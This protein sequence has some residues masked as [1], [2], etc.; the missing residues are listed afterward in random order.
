MPDFTPSCPIPTHG[1]HDRIQLAH[2][3]GGLLMRRW[4]AERLAPALGERGPRDWDDAARLPSFT[5]MPLLTT[6][7]Y[8]VSPLFFPG[9]D[10]GRLAVLGTANDLA[11]AGARPR[12]LTLALI[13]EEG[14]DF[15]T[16]DRVLASVRE[17]ADEADVR[18]VAGDTKVA[19]RGAVDRL[20]ITT[21]GV[22]EL[23]AP[24]PSGVGSLQP[25]DE[26]LVT[27][28]IGRHGVA[29]LAARHALQLDPAPSSDCAALYP[30]FAAL[31]SAGIRWKSARDATRGG[32]TA[33]LHE[34]AEASGR[35]LEIDDSLVPLAA[36]T[37]GVCELLGLDP[38][39]LACEGTS[40]VAVSAHDAPAAL[41]ALRGVNVAREATRL[42]QVVERGAAPVLI[43]RALGRLVPLDEPLGAP[44]PRIC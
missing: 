29:V 37:R 23:L 18:I 14:L 15:E 41:A 1:S 3:E 24:P 7:S 9:G 44:T 42:G 28:P 4:I 16:L 43:R 32:V 31:R 27:G 26:L 30:A 35:T 5:G 40:V 34:W 17:A 22:G 33:V 12:W 11:V 19:P 25:G 21:A 39:A 10:I 20:F 13:L 2:G 36:D 8:V 38:L 6:D